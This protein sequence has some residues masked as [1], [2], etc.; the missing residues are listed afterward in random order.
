[1]PLWKVWDPGGDCETLYRALLKKKSKVADLWLETALYSWG[2]SFSPAWLWFCHQQHTQ[3]DLRGITL[4]CWMIGIQ[5]SVL[6]VD[7]EMTCIP[8]AATFAIICP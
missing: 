8:T 3:K 2:P 1:M 6:A 5:T 4:M 7:P